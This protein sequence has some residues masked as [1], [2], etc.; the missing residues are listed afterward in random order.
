MLYE[1]IVNLCEQ[2]GISIAK[3]EKECGLGNATIQ[4]WKA[5]RDT[6]RFSTMKKVADYFDIS[7]NDLMKNV[8]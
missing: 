5:L 1:N 4:G 3:L 2:R 8:Q 7:V 6:P